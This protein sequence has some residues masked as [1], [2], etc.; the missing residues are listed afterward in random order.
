[1]NTASL[2]QHTSIAH[3]SL[4]AQTSS[5][6]ASCQILSPISE[7]STNTGGEGELEPNWLPVWTSEQLQ[8]MQSHD[9]SISELVCLKQHYDHIPLKEQ[10]RPL[11]K[12]IISLWDRWEILY[13]E[14]GILYRKI[15]DDCEYCNSQLVTPL[16][17]KEIIF[18]QLHEKTYAAHLGRDR[19]IAVVKHRFY[20]PNMTN[21]IMLNGVEN[22]KH[23]LG[24][25]Q[26]LD[27]ENQK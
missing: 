1:M 11:H 15:I 20:W 25:N 18:S 4:D 6:S 16:E 12:D 24:P 3:T 26:V 19:T 27:W 22:A 9:L 14:R 2:G 13:L 17:L 7:A 5:P 10:I 21:N 23:V 8:E